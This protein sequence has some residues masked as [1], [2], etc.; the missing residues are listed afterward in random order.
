MESTTY[1]NFIRQRDG[2]EC[3]SKTNVDGSVMPPNANYAQV[4]TV[5][6]LATGELFGVGF[7]DDI[8][9]NS[10]YIEKDEFPN[11]PLPLPYT[12][13]DQWGYI[14]NESFGKIARVIV[15]II[16]HF[17]TNSE[18]DNIFKNELDSIL[19]KNY[20]IG[21]L[22]NKSLL[23]LLILL[24]TEPVYSDS[25]KELVDSVNPIKE[26][27][28]TP[29]S[30]LQKLWAIFNFYRSHINAMF[31]FTI[32][33]KLGE[34]VTGGV[35]GSTVEKYNNLLKN[36]I[37]TARH[38]SPGSISPT[39]LDFV[40]LIYDNILGMFSTGNTSFL[41]T[42]NLSDTEAHEE[43]TEVG[44]KRKIVIT[45]HDLCRIAP[46]SS[47][48]T[49]R[50]DEE[51]D[52]FKIYDNHTNNLDGMVELVKDCDEDIAET[53]HNTK[54]INGNLHSFFKNIT[55]AHSQNSIFE[56]LHSQHDITI[57]AEHTTIENVTCKNLTMKV[58]GLSKASKLN[59]SEVLTIHVD[60]SKSLTNIN[61]SHFNA[62]K[63]VLDFGTTIDE[64]TV[65]ILHLANG[66]YQSIEYIYG[67]ET[68]DSESNTNTIA[69]LTMLTSKGHIIT[70][71]NVYEVGV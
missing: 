67:T 41:S 34:T 10:I 50:N 46:L 63:V 68:S 52:I 53:G 2:V 42:P 15:D 3:F 22:N 26:Q 47:K 38:I 57:D 5:V 48:K 33:P 31:D 30:M 55:F 28:V 49:Y 65:L 59:V 70:T 6:E 20:T 35:V 71:N 29:I 64:N 21:Q 62:T 18:I 17:N 16:N 9:K 27:N 43:V 69:N 24:R 25:Q 61:I 40:G 4:F 37:I 51:I 58:S 32:I 45:Y 19:K 7:G 23:E 44:D 14:A 54:V 66:L 56:R 12:A 13:K 60:T 36:N 8:I 39:N 11:I 1:F